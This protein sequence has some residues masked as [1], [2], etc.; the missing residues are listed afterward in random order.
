MLTARRLQKRGHTVSVVSLCDPEER[1]VE[2]EDGTIPFTSLGMQ[3]GHFDV[4]AIFKHAASVRSFKPDVVHAHMFHASLL[5]RLSRVLVRAPVHLSTAH[6]LEESSRWRNLAYRLTDP[7]SNLTT[8]VCKRCADRFVERGAVPKSKVL[9]VPN[10]MD[11]SD[12][13]A[14]GSPRN[15]P[16]V[17]LDISDDDFVWLAAGRLASEKDYPNL[18][19]AVALLKQENHIH[20]KVLVAGDGEHRGDLASQ[21]EREGL[22]NHVQLLG[23]R[24][25]VRSLMTASDGFVMSSSS[26]GLPM[27]LLEAAAAR[28]PSVVTDVGGNRELV[29]D[30]TT[31]Y[32]VPPSDPGSL[33]NA[34]NQLAVL[35]KEE[36]SAMGQRALEIAHAEYDM[37]TIVDRWES[38]YYELRN[39]KNRGTESEK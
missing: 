36:L 17:E 25:D 38:L 22:S 12:W 19:R 27:V 13:R 33:A 21:I 3:R 16:L 11:F 34:M 39:G 23:F 1:V 20:H 26:E 35:P 5:S 15:L 37:E 9:Y 7:L 4:R 6:N 8:V 10:G 28:L 2:F 29:K 30:G 32:V 14:E 31:G 24:S 18:L